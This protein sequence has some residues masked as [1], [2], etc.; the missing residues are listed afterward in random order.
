MLHIRS[1]KYKTKKQEIKKIPD[2][3]LYYIPLYQHIG[4]PAIPVVTVGSHVLKNQLIAGSSGSI[5]ANIHAPVS[6]TVEAITKHPLADGREVD[7][8]ILRNDFKNTA[9]PSKAFDIDTATKEQLI[10]TI[11]AAGVVGEGGAQ[12]PTH[13]K[14]TVPSGY[15]IQTFIVNGAE[16]EPY[17]TADYALMQEKT[18]ELFQAIS[19][20]ANRILEAEE[21]VITI[22]KQNSELIKIFAPYLSEYPTVR[23]QVLSNIYPQGG[24]LQVIKSVCGFELPKGSIPGKSGVVVSN[25][26]TI[27]AVYQAIFEQQPLTERILTLSGDT[28]LQTGNFRIKTGTPVQHILEVFSLTEKVKSNLLVVGGPMMG[29][30]VT[31]TRVPITKGSS[32]ILFFDNK[33]KKVDNCISCA[34]CVEA[35]PMHLMPLAFADLYGKKKYADLEKYNLNSCIECAACQYVCPSNVPLMESILKGKDKLKTLNADVK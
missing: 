9:V 34:Y 4:L 23:V 8:V 25:V 20:I 19:L 30:N 6:G 17:L 26:G 31:D 5:S 22:E 18:K 27:Y 21:T 1:R 10:E 15:S 29:K 2:A 32:G 7:T 12:F 33:E 14:Y 3:S 28:L 24:E 11:E 13:V 16:C 35:C